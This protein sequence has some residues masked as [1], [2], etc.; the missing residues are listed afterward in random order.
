MLYLEKII[1]TSIIIINKIYIYRYILT[2][3]SSDV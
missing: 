3:F 1:K 2:N